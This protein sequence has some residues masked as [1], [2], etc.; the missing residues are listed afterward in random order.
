MA[1]EQLINDGIPGQALPV[2]AGGVVV[3]QVLRWLPQRRLV[4]AG[5]RQGTPV[6]AKF[7]AGNAR[8]KKAF[9]RELDALERIHQCGVAAPQVLFSQ[10][11]EQGGQLIMTRLDG[12]TALEYCAHEKRA[13]RQKRVLDLLRWVREAMRKGVMQEDNHL[14]NFLRSEGEW[15]MLDAAACRFGTFTATA[16][17]ANLADLVAQFP[18]MDV[19]SLDGVLA[20]FEAH[21]K[22]VAESRKKRYRKILEKTQR[23]CTE[24]A[25]MRHGN[26]KGMCRREYLPQLAALLDRGVDAAVDG[27]EILK[28]G[29]SSTVVLEQKNHWVIKRYN[30][31]STAHWFKRQWGNTRARNAWL[32]G[33]FLRTIGVRTPLPVAF[34]EEKRGLFTCR[35][36]IINEVA[37]GKAL[38]DLPQDREVPPVLLQDLK[39]LFALMRLLGFSHGDMKATNFIIEKGRLCV[40][41]L[42]AM[43]LSGAA[44]KIDKDA[45]RLLRNWQPGSILSDSI[46]QEVVSGE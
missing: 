43:N 31:K 40:I 33:Y 34:L 38:A 32:A 7:F 42:D 3:E 30:I 21:E 5:Y 35:A 36:W 6:V 15:H 12:Q 27:A 17:L 23:D 13:E 1:V 45:A 2:N 9:K 8:G 20:D 25:C 39:D 26:L 44:R 29:N 10:Y 28:D 18:P 24:F 14:G 41:D 11:D 19:P 46:R 37:E 16:V 22:A 4:V